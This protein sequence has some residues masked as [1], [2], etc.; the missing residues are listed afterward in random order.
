MHWEEHRI[1]FN[2]H[3]YNVFDTVGL[4]EPQLEGK[5]YLDLIVN[6][7]NLIAK[8]H[9]EGGIDLLLFCMRA[10][11][12]TAANQANY[13]LFYEWLCEK[14]V[15]IILVLTGLENEP[16][17]ERWWT[18]NGDIFDQCGIHVIDHACIT[19]ADALPGERHQWLYEESRHL[20]RDLVVQHTHRHG[21]AYTGGEGWF[22]RVMQ[23]VWEMT[24]SGGSIKFIP[25]KKDI[26]AVLTK[27][28][29]MPPK[30]VKE[31][32]SRIRSD[33]AGRQLGLLA[34]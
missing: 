27:H 30:A 12:V 32:A 20:V 11:R 14:K 29:R 17:M 8:L 3:G 23:K 26:E 31:L 34:R 19:A 2:G 21:D 25:K 15:P 5:G 13:R 16:N 9:S 24:A 10:G 18:S 7:Y 22:R 6:A 1:T 28:S 33:L 4:E